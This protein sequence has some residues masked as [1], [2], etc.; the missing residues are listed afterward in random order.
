MTTA[1]KGAVYLVGAG[2]G[3]PELLTLKAADLLATADVVLHD[4]LVPQAILDRAG[5][6]TRVVSVGKRCGD[7]RI[8]QE[9]IHALMIMEA[10]RGS[11]VVRLKSGDPLIFGRAGEE[12]DA[13]EKAE[14]PCEIV[15]GVTSMFAAAAAARKSL[16]DRRSASKVILTTAHHASN[17]SGTDRPSFWRGPLPNDATL[18]IYMPGRDLRALAWDMLQ[19]GMP[20]ELPC[21]VMSQVSL[22]GE[23]RRTTTLGGLGDVV[24]GPAPLLV[25]AGWPLADR[26]EA[27]FSEFAQ[28]EFSQTAA[29][30]E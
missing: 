23:D 6:Q 5:T 21:V 17:G 7:R 11:S 30:M 29:R 2:P 14:I 28:T 1:R 25:L 3:D 24:P 4:D 16:T 8:T 26:P 12:L 10:R 22:P 20:P 18:G 19:G 15:S 9:Q 13:L 27:S